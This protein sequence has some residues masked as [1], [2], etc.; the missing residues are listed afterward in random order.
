[1]IARLIDPLADPIDKKQEKDIVRAVK[2]FLYKQLISTSFQDLIDSKVNW[3]DY[4]LVPTLDAVET[5]TSGTLDEETLLLLPE[6]GQDE[7]DLDRLVNDLADL[8]DKLSSLNPQIE[9]LAKNPREGREDT[10][11]STVHNK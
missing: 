3:S 5:A 9:L 6:D 2:L 11:D 7:F 8:T 1:M 4:K 10:A